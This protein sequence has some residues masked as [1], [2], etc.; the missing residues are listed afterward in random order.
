[1]FDWLRWLLAPPYR[2]VY[3][4]RCG[5][6]VRGLSEWGLFRYESVFFPTREALHGE[7]ERGELD[8]ARHAALLRPLEAACQRLSGEKGI[9]PGHLF[10]HLARLFGPPCRGC[11]KNLRTPQS[12]RC[13]ECGQVRQW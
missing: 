11:G 5:R 3:C 12:S 8:E 9:A 10:Q 4:W 6:F 13:L 1:M 7:K 2:R